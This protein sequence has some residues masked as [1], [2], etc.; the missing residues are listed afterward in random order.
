LKEF[1]DKVAVITGAASG[2][3]RG[4]AERSVEEGMR[5]VMADVDEAL[6]AEVEED[7]KAKGGE[8]LAVR[9]DVAKAEDMDLL[10]QKTMDTYGG[11]HL[12]CN[13]AG[14]AVG[15]LMW[16]CTLADWEWILG[17]N[18]WGV[19]HGIRNFVPIMLEQNTEA[20]VVNTASIEGLWARHRN[21]PYQV[22][23]HAVVALSEVLKLD[24][25]FMETKVGVSV[26]CPGAVNTQIIDSGRNRPAE[27]QNPPGEIPELTPEMQKRIEFIR[28]T[29][30]NGMSPAE[31]ADHVFK[32]VR[33][34]KFYIITHPELKDR[35]KKR[36]DGM[37]NERNPA[38][39]FTI[40]TMP[41][42]ESMEEQS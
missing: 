5:V 3:G 25:D 27:L 2:I 30:A 23:K 22:T 11:V 33:D 38:P 36:V 19:I 39:E 9:T 13:N 28:Q 34:E 20:H 17:V 35:V 42:L 32:A 4:L 6:L 24:L 18:L 21:G 26:L 14:V 12:L 37:M 29:F 1:K 8:V 16:E 40:S 31:C 41:S 15:R 7:L 10:T